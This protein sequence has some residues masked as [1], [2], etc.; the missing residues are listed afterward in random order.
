MTAEE[1]A[2]LAL[3]TIRLQLRGNGYPPVP[4]YQKKILLKEW[5]SK[6]DTREEEIASWERDHPDWVNTGVLTA[7]VP[8]VDIDIKHPEAAD[9]VDEII[10]E[11]F[12]EQGNINPPL[13]R[14]A[15]A[16]H[17]LPHR[18]AVS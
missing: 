18:R 14:S 15:Q 5:T 2:D 3:T 9:R 13:R 12:G 17:L 10:T 11:M 16:L 1:R 4:A 7:T 8:T 6:G